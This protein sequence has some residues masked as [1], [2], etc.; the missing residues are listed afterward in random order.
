M[1]VFDSTGQKDRLGL[2]WGQGW[3]GPG[4]WCFG[5][6]GLYDI[7]TNNKKAA[8]AFDLNGPERRQS[9]APRQR[10]LCPNPGLIASFLDALKEAAISGFQ[11][12]G[13]QLARMREAT[14]KGAITLRELGFESLKPSQRSAVKELVAIMLSLEAEGQTRACG[15]VLQCNRGIPTSIELEPREPRTR[16]QL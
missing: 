10:Q 8:Q 3:N 1:Y 7:L 5:G 15:V 4:I 13:R 6:L 14:E 12:E 16:I 2:F 9:I 11:K